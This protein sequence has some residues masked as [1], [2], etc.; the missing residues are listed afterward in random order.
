MT[1]R[2][3]LITTSAFALIA[4]AYAQEDTT[5]DA[6]DPRIRETITVRATPLRLET[7]DI[8]TGVSVLD[9]DDVRDV[10]AATLG[11]TLGNEPGVSQTFFGPGASRP[12][13]R[14][15]GASRTRIL[16]DGIG[17]FDVNAS[18]PDHIV[19]TE[20]LLAQS[21]EVL[22]G[23]SVLLFGDQAA[24]GI[25]NVIGGAIP[26]EVPE[27]N[28]ALDG[29][30]GYG[31]NADDVS[32]AGGV[33]AG[34]KG[35]ALRIEGFTRRREDYEIDGPAFL[36]DDDHG[37]MDDHDHMEDHGDEGEHGHEG[38]EE[39]PVDVV[40]NTD[41][42]FEG[43]SVGGS[44]IHK[45]GMIGF[46]YSKSNQ[47]Y[48]IPGGAHGHGHEE[49]EHDDEDHEH[50]DEHDHEHGHEE[51]E[52]EEEEIIRLDAQINRFDVV[53]EY[54]LDAI[55][56]KTVRGRFGRGD[57]EH[58]ELE[59]SEVG[60]RFTNEEYESRLE[61]EH[62]DVGPLRGAFG[63]NFRNRE[64]SSIGD[65]AFVPPSELNQYGFFL[66]ERAEFDKAALEGGLRY[67]RT[68]IEP[69][70]S[71]LEGEAAE[72]FAAF[73][74]RDFDTLS[75]SL[76]GSYD[77]VEG[78]RVGASIY[79]TERAPS[80]EE[81]FSNG[82]HLATQTFEIGNPDFDEEVATGGELTVRWASERFYA[83]ANFFY[84][85]YSDFI[86]ELPTGDV[87]EGLPVFQFLATDARFIGGEAEAGVRIFE[88]ERYGGL[89]A[90]VQ[91]D[92]V[93]ARQTEGAENPLPRITPQRLRAG[94]DYHCGT[95]LEARAEVQHV[96]EQDRVAAFEEATDSYTL[97]NARVTLR[98]F[99]EAENVAIVF[100]G[101]N[102]TNSDGRF[103]TSFLRN[104]APLPGRDLQV[105]L[106]FNY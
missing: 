45:R 46:S 40:P 3:L 38:D 4:S 16:N 93:R 22:R 98:P 29:V 70:A 84:T 31:S 63:F 97:L 66:F 71:G 77:L 14:G 62:M 1:S 82:A 17:V 88:T 42:D 25:V 60:T 83:T 8:L 81:L 68:E 94:L 37:H 24:A 74:D 58:V 26:R 91:Y 51:G 44:Y 100:R 30:F 106:R 79:R 11:E 101:L 99:K 73:E 104:F 103:H 27:N 89:H 47:N 56:L 19:E 36:E 78:L 13:I 15:Q 57:Y 53:S 65:E 23:P 43:V 49:D 54:R 12:I 67:T 61:L 10:I 28:I 102:L 33:E 92:V 64:F 7:S 105:Q 6:D 34:M 76:G 41:L 21:I 35:L 87:E 20:P 32:F 18:S 39:S 50:E 2:G 52:E 59:G 69:D 9:R 90:D 55:G 5:F 86:T 96:F 85:D 75:A 95:M 48:G 72:R 80:Q